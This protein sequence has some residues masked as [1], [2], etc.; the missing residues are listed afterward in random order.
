MHCRNCGKEV[1]PQ[2]VVCVSCGIH[3]FKGIK[4]CQ[5]CG[6]E[7]NPQQEICIKCG[8]RLAK[9]APPYAKSKIVA[10]ILG[11]FLGGFGIHRFYLG[12]TGIGIIQIIVTI[13]TCG[14]G[15]LWGFIEGILILT[16]NINKDAQGNDL[17]D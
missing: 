16:G 11:I 14:I 4:Y 5:Y 7:T 3:P 1:N 15:Y 6:A 17:V 13:V 9:V 12:Y 10:G 2:A 8:V